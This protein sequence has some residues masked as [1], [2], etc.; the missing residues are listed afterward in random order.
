MVHDV[1]HLRSISAFSTYNSIMTALLL[2]WNFYSEVSVS[3]LYDFCG[4]SI[5]QWTPEIHLHVTFF[6]SH[7]RVVDHGAVT[8][9]LRNVLWFGQFE[10]QNRQGQQHMQE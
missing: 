5:R 2:F 9:T 7:L 1:C 8:D 10:R 3:N 4:A 6:V